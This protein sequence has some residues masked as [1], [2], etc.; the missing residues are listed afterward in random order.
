[1]VAV[2]SESAQQRKAVD[3]CRIYAFTMYDSFSD[4]F[5]GESMNLL[6]DPAT[7]PWV[8]SMVGFAKATTTLAALVR[9]LPHACEIGRAHV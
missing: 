7:R 3:M 2:L 9:I 1:M 6:G 4:I 5:L 8:D